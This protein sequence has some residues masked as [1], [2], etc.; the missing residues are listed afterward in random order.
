M[1]RV[2][3]LP[4]WTGGWLAIGAVLALA[5]CGEYRGPDPAGIAAPGQS[6]WTSLDQAYTVLDA[7]ESQERLEHFQTLL[8]GEA[9]DVLDGVLAELFPDGVRRPGESEVLRVLSYVAQTTRLAS[10]SRHLGSDVLSDGHAY[11]YGMARAFEALCRRMGLPARIN[12]VHNFQWM[13]A[14]NM[15]EVY[16]DG[17]WRLFDPTYGVFFYTRAE[18][19][20]RGAIP[21]ARAL[22]SGR[23]A[24]DHPFQ[25]CEELWTGA[26]DP[27][28]EV[29]PFPK[30]Y[31]YGRY[32]FTVMELYAHVL[33]TAFPFVQSD[34]EMESFP[35]DIDMGDA[36][37]L[38][39]GEVDGRLEDI[40]GRGPDGRYG[41]HRGTPFLGQLQLGP[42]FH[43]VTIRTSTPGRF[44]MTYHF[45]PQSRFDA[46]ATVE[47]R[48]VIMD[49]YETDRNTWSAVFKLQG[50]EGI[51]LVV[52]R[53][54][55]ALIDAISVTRL[56]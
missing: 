37:S 24:P 12:A 1:N 32:E 43:T 6:P 20:G 52:N 4:R 22:L 21:S 15:A 29:R 46:M 19:D 5:G 25:V 35:L 45:L 10:S 38:T 36:S 31:Q 30:D 42:A 3:W 9:L 27:D 13:Q 47:L 33:A 16:Y 55:T 56:D 51:F 23:I 11:C 54:H 48:D 44:R 17:A 26:Y 34:L 14:H 40:D 7:P 41:R 50:D 53:R 2:Y 8:A 28:W 39:I 49:T 18:Y